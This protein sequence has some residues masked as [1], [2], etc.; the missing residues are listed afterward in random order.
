MPP[1]ILNIFTKIVNRL[2]SEKNYIA[3]EGQLNEYVKYRKWENGFAECWIYKSG[4]FTSYGNSAIPNYRD[5][6]DNVNISGIFIEKPHKI[7]S[8]QMGSGA[9][10]VATGGLNDTV[11]SLNL[12]WSSYGTA[13]DGYWQAYAWGKWK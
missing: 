3:Q 9:A 6:S 12:H 13:A 11:N 10:Y 1:K 7:G 4:T 8:V 5:F 2:K